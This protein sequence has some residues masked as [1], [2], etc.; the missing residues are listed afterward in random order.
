MGAENG[1]HRD[2]D[3]SEREERGAHPRLP[4]SSLMGSMIFIGNIKKMEQNPDTDK[5]KMVLF[6]VEVVS[7]FGINKVL[8][9]YSITKSTILLFIN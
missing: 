5:K 6:L 8:L 4:F 9:F 7:H 3:Q 1:H 2:A